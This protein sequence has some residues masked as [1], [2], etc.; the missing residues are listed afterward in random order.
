V[1]ISGMRLALAAWDWLEEKAPV[2]RV[3]AAARVQTGDRPYLQISPQA[4]ARLLAKISSVK[5]GDSKE[6]VYEKLGKPAADLPPT[7]QPIRKEAGLPSHM[8]VG[9]QIIAYY[10]KQKKADQYDEDFDEHIYIF[11]DQDDLVEYI[12][13]LRQDQPKPVKYPKL[14]PYVVPEKKQGKK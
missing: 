1:V 2:P 7:S 8:V 9:S 13:V 10:I 11:L 5:I 3:A 14:P 12:Y 6:E 4:R